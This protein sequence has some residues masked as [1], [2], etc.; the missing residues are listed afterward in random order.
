MK[1][2]QTSIAFISGCL[3]GLLFLIVL[4]AWSFNQVELKRNE[5][6]SLEKINNKIDALSVASDNL[7]IFRPDEKLWQAFLKDAQSIQIELS[8]LKDGKFNA[9]RVIRHIDQLIQS[10]ADAYQTLP[11]TADSTTNDNQHNPLALP[12]R[13]RL[14]INQVADHGV[15]IES[16]IDQL[17]QDNQQTIES[18]INR[19]LVVFMFSALIFGALCVMAFG[20]I[21]HRIARPTR[22]LINT[23]KRISQNDDT[24]RAEV[25]GQD[26]MAELSLAFNALLDQKDRSSQQILEQQRE[27]TKQANLL[28][29]AGRVTRFGG[30]S[31][32]MTT[33][34]IKWSN[35]V[36]KIHGKPNGYS[37]TI[38]EGLSFYIPEHQPKIT[39]LFN[40]CFESGT[41]YDVELQILNSAG[42]SVWVRSSGEAVRNSDGEIIGVHGACQDISERMELEN[43][44]RQSQRLEAVGQLTGGVA[45]DFNNLLTVV[46]GNSQIL[47][48]SLDDSSKLLPLAKMVLQAGYRGAELTR[49]LLAF[50][51]KQPLDPKPVDVKQLIKLLWPLLERAVGAE[52][53]IQLI[54]DDHL[55][56]IMVDAGQFENAL[57]NLALNAKDAMPKGGQLV[58]EAQNTHLPDRYAQAHEI[59][60]GDYVVVAISDSGYGIAVDKLDK[61]FEPFYTT[62]PKDKGTGLGLAMVYGFIKQSNG[63]VNIYSEPDQGTTV[64]LYLPVAGEN[65][66]DENPKML[67]TVDVQKGHEHILVV[68]DDALVR[69]YVVAQLKDLG[70]EVISAED[71]KQ[72]MQI[73]ESDQLIDL[74]LTDVILPEGLNGRKIAENALKL[75]PA[76]RV[77]YTSGY[78][79][80]SIVHHG[81]LDPGV[82]LLSKPYNREELASKVRMALDGIDEL[83]ST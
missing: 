80:N 49:S 67:K 52:I 73:L 81:R 21:Y 41:P 60:P 9:Q 71:G 70:Y 59:D 40:K 76:L 16:A 22:N 65:A 24:A 72:A 79:E 75:R 27:L 39:E 3:L 5:H 61:V 19:I 44:L 14:L 50:A 51:R 66:L 53:S 83:P 63:H 62:K 47:T 64:R 18:H 34:K 46:I 54:A 58:I 7:L 56:S 15:A 25:I 4:G 68:E 11:E 45:H 31:V 77:L 30:W 69:D 8:E 38:E 57:L 36:A 28:E 35:M 78:T 29:I 82:L 2:V 20:L 48:E 33:Q 10:V 37:P 1:L 55:Q 74:L 26:E 6:Y 17:I 12:L 13:S 42:E 43:R 23:I 32:D